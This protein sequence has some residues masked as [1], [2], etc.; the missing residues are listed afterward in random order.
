MIVTI[1]GMAYR[2]A[3]NIPEAELTV[4]INLSKF[5]CAEV[6]KCQDNTYNMNILLTDKSVQRLYGLSLSEVE[7]FNHSVNQYNLFLKK[8]K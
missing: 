6:D 1:N 5:V 4:Y 2:P 8:G 3:K 7:K